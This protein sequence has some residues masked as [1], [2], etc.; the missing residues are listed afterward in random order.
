MGV[1]QTILKQLGGNKFITMTGAKNLVADGNTLKMTL[2]RNRSKANTL[3]ITYN[4]GKDS[5]KMEFL[6]FS[7]LRVNARTGKV[8]DEKFETIKKYGDVYF[9]QLQ[10][11]FTSV[12]GMHTRL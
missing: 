2:P 12:T 10:E 1:A 4:R 11:L 6:K 8:T 7:D 5:Y 9:D 3:W